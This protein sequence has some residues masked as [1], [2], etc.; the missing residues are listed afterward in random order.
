MTTAIIGVGNVG[1]ALARHLAGGGE[2]VVLA[3]RDESATAALAGELGSLASA[4]S[5]PEAIEAA[6]VVVLAVWFDALKQVITDYG[7]LLDGKV[8]ADPSN[9]LGFNADGTPFRTL[10]EGQSQGSLV[11]AML[12]AGAHYVKALGTLSA[13]SLAS[14]ANR[15]PRRAVLFYATDDDRA[16]AA[17]ERLITVCGFDPVKAGGVNEAVR[18]EMPGGDLHQGG[19]LGG[20]LLDA[21]QARAA[22]AAS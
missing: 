18:L 15:A 14:S 4:A 5:V 17:I 2:P 12:P 13:G 10:P 6:D 3:A 22:V 16:A 1:G 21:D 20:K 19:G 9:P 7:D 11:A 8:V